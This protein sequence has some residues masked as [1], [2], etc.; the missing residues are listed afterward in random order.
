MENETFVCMHVSK[1]YMITVFVTET[2]SNDTKNN[3]FNY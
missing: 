1:K 2:Q 3:C